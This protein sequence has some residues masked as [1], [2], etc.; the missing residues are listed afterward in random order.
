MGIFYPDSNATFD[1]FHDCPSFW[2]DKKI[3]INPMNVTSEE[4]MSNIQTAAY[5]GMA[6][7]AAVIV[8]YLVSFK[9]IIKNES[10]CDRLKLITKIVYGF[11]WSFTDSI[12]GNL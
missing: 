5:I 10:G 7:N 1:P 9:G 3:K 8:A 4:Y 11:F 6:L 12:S 2:R